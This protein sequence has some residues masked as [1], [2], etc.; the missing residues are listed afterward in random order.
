MAL[1]GL[2]A[3]VLPATEEEYIRWSR[4]MTDEMS[5][6]QYWI[7]IS[8]P[9]S[10]QRKTLILDLPPREVREAA[11][12]Y[13]ISVNPYDPEA[14]TTVKTPDYNWQNWQIKVNGV[15][16][17]DRPAGPYILRGIHRV[18]FPA[19]LLREKENTISL[20]WKKTAKSDL[21][22]KKF[23]Y[24]YLAGDLTGENENVSGKPRYQ[25]RA[26]QYP[27]SLRI[28]LLLNF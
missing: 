19:D 27:E 1:F 4:V 15:T 26:K 16:I 23:G 21:P 18:K 28:R 9:G 10:P 20:G 14:R 17:L 5:P 2:L 8:S 7:L 6:R 25:V 12:E 3:A 13:E 24:V 11:V 22:G